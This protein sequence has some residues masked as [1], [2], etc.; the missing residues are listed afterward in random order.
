[1]L[2]A[3]DRLGFARTVAL[4]GRHAAD[5]SDRTAALEL[6]AR[7]QARLARLPATPGDALD[8]ARIAGLSAW[9]REALI[10][11][12]TYDVESVPRA[13]STTEL[14]WL[15]G[16]GA[17]LRFVLLDAWG[18]SASASTGE[19]ATRFPAARPWEDAV[20]H[21]ANGGLA[22]ALADLNLR[23][24]AFLA[25][26]KLPSALARDVLSAATL[27]LINRVDAPRADDWRTL[28]EAIRAIPDTRLEDYVAALTADGPL[29]PLRD[30]E[31]G[32]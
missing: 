11:S 2:P 30:G 31:T 15:G 1:V 22:A 6:A 32:Q 28:V 5:D 21:D 19:L 23:V 13:L 7:G 10:W 20:S 8:V 29:R 24:A 4:M 27:E 25:A 3:G 26:R 12:I 9:R 14:A 16:D 18:T 17:P